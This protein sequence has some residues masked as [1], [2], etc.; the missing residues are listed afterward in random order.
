M[1]NFRL[2]IIGGEMFPHVLFERLRAITDAHIVHAYGPTE[3]TIISNAKLL[4]DTKNITVGRPLSGVTE[5][6]ADAQGRPLHTGETGEL[7][8]GGE[9]VARGYLERPGLNAQKFVERDGI[10]Y[11]KS[12]DL[13]KWTEDGEVIILGRN[14]SQVKLHGLRIELGEIEAALAGIS[15]VI[16]CVAQVRTAKKHQ[17]L[18]AWFTAHRTIGV[19]ELRESMGKH[20]AAYMVPTAFMQLDEIPHTLNGKVDAKKL[21]DI[22]MKA[23]ELIA[24]GTEMEGVVLSRA[25]EVLAEEGEEIELGITSELVFLGLTSLGAKNRLTVEVLLR[26]GFRWPLPD[27]T[28]LANALENLKALGFFGKAVPEGQESQDRP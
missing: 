12:G 13:A 4:A 20:L 17:H 26:L 27:G 2:I 10:R 25:A 3:T 19:D 1:K 18:C 8:I 28:Y 21:P 24:P 23:D 6:I 11:F 16:E 9:R 5:I 14:D 22:A 15:G 7:W